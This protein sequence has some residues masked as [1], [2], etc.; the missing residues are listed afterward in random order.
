M[1]ASSTEKLLQLD[2]DYAS[3]ALSF[4]AGTVN[5]DGM[6]P[7]LDDVHALVHLLDPNLARGEDFDG[8]VVLLAS[9]IVGPVDEFISAFTRLPI[10]FV[11]SLGDNLRANGTWSDGH[12]SCA[13]LDED[14]GPVSF[15]LDLAAA[16]GLVDLADVA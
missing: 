2:G 8:A 16:Q 10:E 3:L 4:V 9:L 12:V 6:T 5:V 1:T 13:W 14:D 11:T 7:T 15:W